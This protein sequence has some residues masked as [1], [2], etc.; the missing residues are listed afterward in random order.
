MAGEGSADTWSF[1]DR[2]EPDGRF[3]LEG[4]FWVGLGRSLSLLLTDGI[5]GGRTRE[6]PWL[7]RLFD[8]RGFPRYP[9]LYKSL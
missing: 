7:G 9:T 1:A 6:T 4:A 3:G 5:E 2:C 8:G